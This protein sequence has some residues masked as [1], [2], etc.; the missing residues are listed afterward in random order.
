MLNNLEKRCFENLVYFDGI[1]GLTCL[2]V[3]LYHYTFRYSEIYGIEPFTEFFSWGGRAGVAIFFLISGFLTALT[4]EKILTKGSFWWIKHKILRL[5]PH[6]I[7]ASVIVTLCLLFWGL[8]GRD[9]V[10]VESVLRSLVMFPVIGHTVDGA[11]WYVFSLVCFYFVFLLL[12]KTKLF[13]KEVTYIVILAIHVSLF[14]LNYSFRLPNQVVNLVNTYYLNVQPFVGVLLYL[15]IFKRKCFFVILFFFVALVGYKTTFIS[16]LF[17]ALLSAIL[18]NASQGF[19]KIF[20]FIFRGKILVFIGKN[21]FM[22]YL[23]HQNIGYIIITNVKKLDG[24]AYDLIPYFTMLI[25]F[26]MAVIMEKILLQFQKIVA[27]NGSN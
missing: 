21:S 5:Y 22:W 18:L 1:K 2:L 14:L 9:I 7:F 15:A 3:V 10:T 12:K 8:P 16:V 26:I 13:E 19:V 23:L 27:P 11:H 20:D 24:I 4:S 17:I 25:T 6:Y